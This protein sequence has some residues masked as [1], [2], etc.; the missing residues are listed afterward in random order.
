[1]KFV[2][3]DCFADKEL[4]GFIESQNIFG[5]CD[6]C[7]NKA[8]EI[9]DID[10]TLEFFSELMLNFSLKDGEKDLFSQI[11]ENW[12][13]FREPKTGIEI[14]N[15]VLSRIH[16]EI[17]S[18]NATV[19]FNE[20]VLDNIN[21]WTI[22]KEKLIWETRYVSNIEYLTEDLGWDSFF[23]SKVKIGEGDIFYRGRLHHNANEDIFGPN[24][25]YAPPREDSVAGRANPEGIPFLYLSDNESTV[26]YEVRGSFLDEISIGK[27]VPLSS[28]EDPIIISDFTE[29]PALFYPGEVNKRIK[30]TLLKKQIS[31]DLSRPMRRYDSELDYIPTQFICE[32][33]KVFTNVQGIKFKS[34]VHEGGN[35]IVIFDESIMECTSVK[36]VKV[37]EVRI[38]SEDL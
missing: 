35:N 10:E 9:I 11:Q 21:Y 4:I 16:S 28:M 29:T 32:F 34:S 27:F 37:S 3:K 31:I 33:I 18:A 6:V 1:M 24:E 36:K 19:T 8:I 26:L 17:S 14:L 15:E 13:F 38:Q 30:S 12:D 7:S 23:E 25:M 20:E 2:C 5:D 22:F